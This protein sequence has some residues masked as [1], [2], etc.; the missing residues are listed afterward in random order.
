LTNAKPLDVAMVDGSGNQ[1]ISF[2]P[3]SGAM[4]L[5]DCSAARKD[6]FVAEDR[7]CAYAQARARSRA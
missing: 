1:I 7:R 6:P 2:G 3:P 4:A 5:S